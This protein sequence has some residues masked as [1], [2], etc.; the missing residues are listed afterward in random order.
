M[1]KESLGTAIPSS[2][3]CG[4]GEALSRR[5]LIVACVNEVTNDGRMSSG[6]L[7]LEFLT[8]YRE[9]VP[10]GQRTLSLPDSGDV[11]RDAEAIRK[12]LQ[13]WCNGQGMHLPVEAEEPLVM[14]LPEPYRA[15]LIGMLAA[16]YGL[17]PLRLAELE[18]PGTEPAD[19]MTTLADVLRHQHTNAF[20][21]ITALDELIAS[22]VAMR[23]QITAGGSGNA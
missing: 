6:A 16:R 2:S 19:L 1:S 17:L 13:R 21:A 5:G 3:R 8:Q 10:P 15:N 7:A 14:A 23:L 22:A 18:R 20:A 12:T 4:Q 11:L 9:L